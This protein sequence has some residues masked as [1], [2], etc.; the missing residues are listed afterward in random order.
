MHFNSPLIE[1]R[2]IKRYKRFLAD[3]VIG[4]QLTPITVHCPNTG[5]MLNCQSKGAKIWCS[6]SDN[7]KRKYAMTW[8][9]IEICSPKTT[10]SHLACV[11]TLRANQIIAEALT[12]KVLDPFLA[13]QTIKKEV[14]Y[15][16]GSRVDFVL[17]QPHQ[18][19]CYI[20]VKSVTLS[21]ELEV[22][23]FPDAV[24]ERGVRHLKELI[25]QKTLGQRAVLLFCAQHTGI[26]CIKPADHIDSLYGVMLRKAD[27]AGVEILAYSV[28]ISTAPAQL[29]LSKPLPVIL[30]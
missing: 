26:T 22:G 3:I 20:E 24:T 30:H 11:N 23:L 21:E 4:D 7:P 18:P 12:L 2:L 16:Q 15:G 27:A 9:L 29:L 13:Y 10:H 5:S 25:Y 6:T 8:E 14:R 17:T 19:D 28:E 1:G